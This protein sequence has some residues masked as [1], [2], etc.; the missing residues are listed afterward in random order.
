[1]A[2]WGL[3]PFSLWELHSS[4]VLKSDERPKKSIT[5]FQIGIWVGGDAEADKTS[6]S[7]LFH[8]PGMKGHKTDSVIEGFRENEE[9]R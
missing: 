1:M 4:F 7:A 3:L 8:G 6:K 9:H 2:F 5:C